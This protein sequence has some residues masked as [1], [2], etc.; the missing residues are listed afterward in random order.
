MIH[1][2]LCILVGK[3]ATH[4]LIFA[5]L[6]TPDRVKHGL[7]VFIVPIRD[8]KT[9]LPLPGVTIGDMGEK[10]GLNGIDNGFIIFDKY[11][12]SHT[13]LLNRTADVTKDGKYVLTIKDERKR[14]GRY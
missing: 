9:H 1:Y 2:F 5:Q 4:A 7:H 11:S 3:S 14:Y 10:I 8:S 6:I 12:I 13:C